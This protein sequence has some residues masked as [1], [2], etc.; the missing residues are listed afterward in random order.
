[1]PIVNI[2]D[3]G[4][5]NFPDDMPEDQ[6]KAAAAK[7]YQ[8]KHAVP[9]A[10]DLLQQ[11]RGPRLPGGYTMQ[12]QGAPEGLVSSTIRGMINPSPVQGLLQDVLPLM[13]GRVAGG[14][15]SNASMGSALSGIAEGSGEG[16]LGR[17]RNV[18]GN[19]A[20]RLGSK[21]QPPEMSQSPAPAP[22]ATTP[23]PSGGPDLYE[24]FKQGQKPKPKGPAPS[25]PAAKPSS[26]GPNMGSLVQRLEAMIKN[27][28]SA[29][30]QANLRSGESAEDVATRLLQSQGGVGRVTGLK[31]YP[32]T[33]GK[34]DAATLR[35]RANILSDMMERYKKDPSSVPEPWRSLFAGAIQ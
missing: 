19:T 34:G 7:L 5:V 35:Q 14:P 17:L 8:S 1:M 33:P 11:N 13:A 20:D 32:M 4:R 18:L 24:L 28:P 25:A 22:A 26:S 2:P 21:W 16:I 15:R 3:V 6:I 10:P 27:N 23:P 12:E 29:M 9:M 31:Q 30:Q